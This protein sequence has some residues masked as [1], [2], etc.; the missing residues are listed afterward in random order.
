MTSTNQRTRIP[1]LAPIQIG[2]SWYIRF[3]YK[4]KMLK[5]SLGKGRTA[6][7]QATILG[8]RIK[9]DIALG[10][11]DGYIVLRDKYP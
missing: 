8:E 11:F 6:Y 7:T 4:G 1:N 3:S 5:Q 10:V 9:Q 2:E